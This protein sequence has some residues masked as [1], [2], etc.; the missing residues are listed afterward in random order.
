MRNILLAVTGLNPQILTETLYYYTVEATPPIAFDEV[1]V[2]TTVMGKRLIEELLLDPEKGKY[3]CLCKDYGIHGI[4]FDVSCIEVIG[5]KKPLD[6]I[7][8]EEDNGR[9][10]SHILKIVKQLANDPSVVLYCSIAGGRKT[11]G[12]YLSL[13]LQLYGRAQDHLSHVLVT[14]EFESS[15]DF[16][17]K[18]PRDTIIHGQDANKN[19]V[20]LNTRNAH[21]ELADIP[22]VRVRN[23][24][25]KNRNFPLEEMIRSMQLRIEGRRT[26]TTIHLDIKQKKLHISD[27]IIKL[28]P[29]LL[30]LY[31]F[32]LGRK[33]NCR[34]TNCKD[35]AECYCSLADLTTE[36]TAKLIL[37]LYRRVSGPFS[38]QYEKLELLWKKRLPDEDHFMQAVSRI[39]KKLY[40]TVSEYDY[41]LVEIGKVGGYGE[42][43]YGVK[44]DK[45][46][47]VLRGA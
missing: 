15:R 21:I 17:Y 19:V 46:L 7:R 37:D 4:R 33:T 34:K 26:P 3:Y 47:V 39:N 36:S 20:E 32:F 24:L 38:A 2:I 42:K 44:L 40:Q 28:P 31:A 1:R 13:A 30:T 12:A 45:A 6:D 43:R 5:G 25:P 35:C 18:P 22:F 11:M 14:P 8:T 10:A 29:I 9:M 27:T 41:P 23:Y 16:F